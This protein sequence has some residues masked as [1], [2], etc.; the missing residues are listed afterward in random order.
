MFFLFSGLVLLCAHLA[1]ALKIVN[2]TL[3]T[4]TLVVK[5]PSRL[6]VLCHFY[7]DQPITGN[8]LLLE[9]AMTPEKKKDDISIL[10]LY[11]NVLDP[12]Q[13]HNKRAQV[14]V[15]LVPEGNCSLVIN[16]TCVSDSG[17]YEVRL[18]LDGVLYFP[19][20]IIKIQVLKDHRSNVVDECKAADAKAKNVASI[21]SD[22]AD[23]DENETVSLDMFYTT[24]NVEVRLNQVDCNQFDPDFLEMVWTLQKLKKE[25]KLIPLFY[26][27]MI[28]ELVLCLSFVAALVLGIRYSL[29][30]IKIYKQTESGN[31]DEE[32]AIK[33][34]D[35]KT[36][37]K[38]EGIERD[39]VEGTTDEKSDKGNDLSGGKRVSS[40]LKFKPFVDKLQPTPLSPSANPLD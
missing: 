7:T 18:T 26:G 16:P 30:W 6:L 29:L 24:P 12:I 28:L 4:D 34:T 2:V 37:R 22:A 32:A 19:N 1:S 8:D 3:S 15:S 5:S 23:N 31:Y 17:I 20:P 25:N 39:R 13:S 21:D 27:A 36:N 11:D 33:K 40:P 35:N 14:F 9:W 10:R 38:V